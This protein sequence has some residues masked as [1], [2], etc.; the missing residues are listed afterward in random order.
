[1]TSVS[2]ADKEGTRVRSRD[3]L[4]L[5]GVVVL[6]LVALSAGIAVAAAGGDSRSPANV[7]Q[8]PGN[9]QTS[10]QNQ[11]AQ[12][13][14]GDDGAADDG[15]ASDDDG[16]TDD[17]GSGGQDESDES[18]TGD[19]ATR[20]SEAALAAT[21]GGT[22]VAIES[23]GGGAGYEVEIRKADG[24]EAEVELDKDFNVFQRAGDD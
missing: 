14:P 6:S 9:D 4:I 20:A 13:E 10:M 8:Q 1:M 16:A 15:G 24:S 5:I 22:V 17:D 2:P 7:S 23:E 18:L 19:A 12:T 3:K 11:P 21:G